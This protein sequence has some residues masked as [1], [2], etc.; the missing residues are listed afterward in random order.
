MGKIDGKP[1]QKH[2]AKFLHT[3]QK[4]FFTLLFSEFVASSS[5]QGARNW[6]EEQMRQM[7]WH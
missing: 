1:K 4:P 6:T 2:L 3:T 7:S 5:Q